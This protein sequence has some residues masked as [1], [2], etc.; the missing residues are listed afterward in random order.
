[1]PAN[2][3]WDLD[4]DPALTFRDI[5]NCTV[6][7]WHTAETCD[8]SDCDPLAPTLAWKWFLQTGCC[9]VG[10]NTA[11]GSW[12]L[13][14]GEFMDLSS[15]GADILGAICW[16]FCNSGLS[17]PPAFVPRGNNPWFAVNMDLTPSVYWCG[18]PL[19]TANCNWDHA[20]GTLN[21]VL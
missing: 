14:A 7:N 21:A 1:V 17:N 4:L 11:F 20:A 8:L 19:G 10:G 6:Y 12:K 16:T 5:N 18:V 3:E 15:S 9:D 2:G 13:V